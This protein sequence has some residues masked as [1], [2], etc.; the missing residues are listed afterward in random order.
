MTD[1]ITDRDPTPDDEGEHGA[2]LITIGTP[3]GR[4]VR[5]AFL[6]RKSGEWA[7]YINAGHAMTLGGV[8][9]ERV[10]AWAKMPEPFGG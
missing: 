6:D 2:V 4:I 1:W 5:H 9:R 7:I 8:D 3:A 10:I